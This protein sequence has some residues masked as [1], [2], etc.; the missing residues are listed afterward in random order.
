MDTFRR[1]IVTAVLALLAA[2][3]LPGCAATG[4]AYHYTAQIMVRFSPD[5]GAPEKAEFVAALSRDI[6]A[7]LVYVRPMSGGAHVFR[8]EGLSG[9]DQLT[10]VLK[11]LRQRP[12]VIY[13]EQEKQI[14][15]F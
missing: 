3:P 12:D 15:P 4:G 9:P 6:G 14:V 13:A 11:M 8:V 10:H 7:T 1:A 2:I 5:V